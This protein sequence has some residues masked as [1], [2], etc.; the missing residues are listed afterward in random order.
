MSLLLVSHDLSVIAHMTE[1]VIVMYAGEVVEEDTTENIINNPEHPYT[2]EL[3]K[4]AFDLRSANQRHLNVLSG[5]VPRP[6]DSTSGCKFAKR[7]Q[8][9]MEI[10]SMKS[11]KFN[12]KT[13]T[14]GRLRCWL[15]EGGINDRCESKTISS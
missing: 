15:A 3:V 10:C 11:P 5:T 12:H 13:N 14:K 6:E 2:K 8:F 1:N 9:S 4:A 7:C